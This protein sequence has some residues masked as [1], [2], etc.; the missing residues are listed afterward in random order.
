MGGCDEVGLIV[1]DKKS[2]S[3]EQ[4]WWVSSPSVV[5]THRFFN[6]WSQGFPG[7]SVVKNQPADTRD[8]GSIPDPGR[9]HMPQSN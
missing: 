9:S 2:R 6:G 5:I 1:I 7:G 3:V 8:V 4:D